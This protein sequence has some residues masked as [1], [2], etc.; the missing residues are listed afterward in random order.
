MPDYRKMYLRLFDAAEEVIELLSDER[1]GYRERAGDAFKEEP[2]L[3]L[4]MERARI[5]A[6]I[7]RLIAA[8]QDCEEMVMSEPEAPLI[9]L[10]GGQGT[11]QQ[12][13][14]GAD[15]AGAGRGE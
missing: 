11:G 2:A 4:G 7:E 3:L 9:L 10:P 8:Q 12:P 13:E 6:A 14:E 5:Q 1:R 15:P